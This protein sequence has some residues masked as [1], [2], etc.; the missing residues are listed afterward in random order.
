MSLRNSCKCGLVLACSIS[1]LMGCGGSAPTPPPVNPYAGGG[2]VAGGGSTPPPT[3][4][5]TP[6]TT[7][8][9]APASTAS[10]PYGGQS[11]STVSN[12]YGAQSS[13]PP[14]TQAETTKPVPIEPPKTTP[15]AAVVEMKPQPVVPITPTPT[16]T[17][18]L[19]KPVVPV[20]GTPKAPSDVP[21]SPS[22]SLALDPAPRGGF[23]AAGAKLGLKLPSLGAIGPDFVES[24]RLRVL[25]PV[26][27]SPFVALGLN[28]EK[29]Q[30]REIWNVIERKKLGQVRNLEF[31]SSKGQALSPD[32]QYLAGKPQWDSAI[33]VFSLAL[34]K[35]LPPIKLSGTVSKLVA[36]AGMSRLVFEDSKE[37][38][39]FS[40]PEFTPQAIVKLGSWKVDDGWAI[41]PGGRYFVQVVRS[42][43][44]A[45]LT[46]I[47]LDSGTMAATLPLTGQPECL[48]VAFSVDGQQLA[49]WL[50]GEAP[51]LRVWQVETGV[52]SRQF[53]LTELAEKIVSRENYQGGALEW[54][55]DHRHLLI[56]GKVV[57]DSVE[58][59]QVAE[60]ESPPIYPVRVVSPDQLAIAVNGVLVTHDL[61]AEIKASLVTPAMESG[62]PETTQPVREAKP[63]DRTGVVRV[64][65]DEVD[66]SV[67]LGKRPTPIKATARGIEIP[68]GQIYMGCLSQ[69]ASGIGYVMYTSDPLALN[70]AGMLAT[71][72]GTRFWLET[73]DLKTGDKQKSVPLPSLSLLMSVSQDGTRVCTQNADGLDQLD[74]LTVRGAVNSGSLAPYHD[75][76]PGPD[77]RVRY[78]EFLDNFTLLTTAP[79]RMTLWD[80]ELNKA[81]YEAE[82]GDLRPELSPARDYVAVSDVG[83]R[84]ICLL[85]SK[86]GKPAGSIALSELA[87]DYA[88]ACAF[89]PEGRFFAALTQRLDG[90]ELRVIDLSTGETKKQFPLPVSGK[91]LQWVGADYLLINGRSLVSVSRECVVWNYTLPGGM[92]LRDSP[93]QRHWYIA[94]EPERSNVYNVRGIDMPDPTIVA[95]IGAANLRGTTLLSPGRAIDLD[96][97]VADPAGETG[98]SD[99]VK[100]ILTDRYLGAR[101]KVIPGAPISLT[102]RNNNDSGWSLN[103]TQDGNSIWTH[104]IDGADG[105][106]A[107][108]SFEPPKHAFPAGADRGAGQS[109]LTV[110]GSQ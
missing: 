76:A 96:V 48:G 32:G 15:P 2:S 11:P 64:D 74:I 52:L 42:G 99:K 18:T 8:V 55:P 94:S 75:A 14:K 27:P 4:G 97:Q 28:D 101:I 35:A 39:V 34:N 16:P 31:G 19:D 105:P 57:Y 47:D 65:L 38:R 110:R 51:Q 37:L 93:D 23:A 83:Q 33:S 22:W 58:G 73:L 41:S 7:P 80:I 54:F 104:E 81:L 43:K 88:A 78:A 106:S 89:H 44:T 63:G 12:P 107:L 13:T 20:E 77:Q 69:S 72:P 71:P 26:T 70:A 17:P 5:T 21:A 1:W 24:T 46:M 45:G 92:H 109:A 68:Q 85:E 61:S 84:T 3:A 10:N 108:L 50:G 59:T 82:I 67:K 60:L 87:E 102:V 86:T 62:T 40:V 79:G 6:P 90:G 98:F 56:A 91:V 25:Y 95:R 36:F 53:D 9:T 49:V 30:Y 103:L 66:W 100:A 29:K